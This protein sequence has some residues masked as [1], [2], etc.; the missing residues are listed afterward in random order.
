M[1]GSSIPPGLLSQLELE[2]RQYA[3]RHDKVID[4][5]RLESTL[6]AMDRFQTGKLLHAQ[7]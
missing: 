4:L 7:V 6:S 1:N 2:L 3:R 5:E